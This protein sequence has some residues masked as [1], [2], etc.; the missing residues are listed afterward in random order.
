MR[1]W[2][3]C[4][5]IHEGLS[6]MGSK[7]RTP[8]SHLGTPPLR[9]FSG[10]RR[11]EGGS[12]QLALTP[13]LKVTEY[14]TWNARPRGSRQTEETIVSAVPTVRDQLGTAVASGMADPAEW[15]RSKHHAQAE[16]TR[17]G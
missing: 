6:C 11:L 9:K 13:L 1:E 2:S 16:L 12:S 4:P 7:V 14:D 10:P 8:S 5:E 15:P 17:T 3:I